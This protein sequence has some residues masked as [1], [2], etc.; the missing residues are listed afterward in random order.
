MTVERQGEQGSSFVLPEAGKEVSVPTEALTDFDVQQIARL[1]QNRKYPELEVQYKKIAELFWAGNSAQHL[2]LTGSGIIALFNDFG[3]KNMFIDNPRAVASYQTIQQLTATEP[4]SPDTNVASTHDNPAVRASGLVGGITTSSLPL[5]FEW[6]SISAPSNVP[7]AILLGGT[8]LSV[9]LFSGATRRAE[10][11]QQ[12]ADHYTAMLHTLEPE[13]L[14]ADP[15]TKESLT[16]PDRDIYFSKLPD[17]QAYLLREAFTVEDYGRTNEYLFNGRQISD[18]VPELA[19]S[20]YGFNPKQ[21][22]MPL[23][24]LMQCELF[25]SNTPEETWLNTVREDALFF[26]AQE[27]T[28][29]PLKRQYEEARSI[30]LFHDQENESAD[31]ASLRESM[32]AVNA[33]MQSRV[34]KLLDRICGKLVAK[35]VEE[36]LRYLH[37]DTSAIDITDEGGKTQ[38]LY[39]DGFTHAA[40]LFAKQLTELDA[41]HGGSAAEDLI[42]TVRQAVK[43]ILK[44]QYPQDNEEVEREL[45]SS[46]TQEFMTNFTALRADANIEAQPPIFDDIFHPLSYE[47]PELTRNLDDLQ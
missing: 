28:L 37:K 12:L 17:D 13:Q 23:F 4:Y 26:A 35:D 3:R 44:R 36:Q 41:Y 46:I 34:E 40:E 5:L 42:I 47:N 39:A 1:I 24:S 22:R 30:R 9:G 18:A 7:I 10:Q 33:A 45:Y 14:I 16:I 11:K 20:R 32:A 43:I 31:E 21:S 27:E 15:N 8:A 2:Y 6:L 38:K 25:L 29:A 19:I